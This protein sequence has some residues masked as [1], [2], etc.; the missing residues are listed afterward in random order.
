MQLLGNNI[1]WTGLNIGN[2]GNLSTL[3][4]YNYRIAKMT[5]SDLVTLLNQMASRTG[6]LPASASISDL[7]NP[8][9]TDGAVVAALANLQTVKGTTV[10]RGG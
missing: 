2:N 3:Y 4:L 9:S 5:D 10:V 6:S 8:T 1:N 7:A